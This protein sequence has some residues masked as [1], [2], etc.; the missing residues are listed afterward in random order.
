MKIKRIVSYLLIVLCVCFCAFTFTSCKTYKKTANGYELTRYKTT[1]KG[2][3]IPSVYKGKPVTSIG[4]KAFAEFRDMQSLIIPSTVTHIG[5]DAFLFCSNLS[6]LYYEGSAT[7][8]CQIEFESKN[9]NPIHY[10]NDI[11]FNNREFSSYVILEEGLT[12]IND[13]AFVN[14][15]SLDKIVIP[16]TVTTIGK[17]AFAHCTNLKEVVLPDGLTT[18]KDE[19]FYNCYRL[20]N[21]AIPATVTTIGAS[22]FR[23]Y[24]GSLYCAVPAPLDGWHENWFWGE[25]NAKVFW[26]TTGNRGVTNDGFIWLETNNGEMVIRGYDG[27]TLPSDL[28]IPAEINGKPVVEIAE[29]AF[30]EHKNL[31]SLTLPRT[32]KKIGGNAFGYTVGKRLTAVY[33]NGFLADWLSI[34]FQMGLGF[35]ENLYIAGELVTEVKIP[36]Q[37]TKISKY[38]FNNYKKLE[39]I[40]IHKFV[41]DMVENTFWGCDNVTFY[42]EATQRPASWHKNWHGRDYDPAPVVW[43]YQA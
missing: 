16:S 31:N 32:I 37:I 11:Y 40:F 17:E 2:V 24:M 10:T 7:Q 1:E 23:Q 5:E 22:A 14:C 29:Q 4:K 38:A 30:Y 28:V 15:E 36:H 3:K 8:W 35:T 39:K 42:C 26:N 12:Q 18:I 20:P 33:F 9:A 34:D 43:G 19:A 6:M 25:E 21:L 27:E 41:E 13:F